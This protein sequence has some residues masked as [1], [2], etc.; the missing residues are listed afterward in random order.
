MTQWELWWGKYPLAWRTAEFP[1]SREGPPLPGVP[2]FKLIAA[3]GLIVSVLGTCSQCRVQWT[4]AP[5]LAGAMFVVLLTANIKPR[6]LFLFEPFWIL[7][8]MALADSCIRFITA[9]L[10]KLFR[11]PKVA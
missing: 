9:G 4:F 10:H 8:L 6:F 11:R 3:L 5:V 7:Y 1:E 2:W